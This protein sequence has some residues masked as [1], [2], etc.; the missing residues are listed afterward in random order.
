MLNDSCDIQWKV[1]FVKTLI[2]VTLI[3]SCKSSVR[4]YIHVCVK[5]LSEVLY[6]SFCIDCYM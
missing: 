4:V 5:Y 1:V 2:L 3:F 6:I